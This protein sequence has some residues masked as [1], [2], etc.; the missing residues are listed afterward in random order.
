[1]TPL[2]KV[3]NIPT[4]TTMSESFS[5]NVESKQNPPLQP[6]EKSV[7]AEFHQED[8]STISVG[9]KHSSKKNIRPTKS[10]KTLEVVL[11]SRGKDL[12]QFWN[13][14]AEERS[15]NLWLPTK[16]GCVVSDL[17]CSNSLSHDSPMEK[18]LCSVTV[19]VPKTKNLCPIS[20]PSSLSSLLESTDFGST[21][22]VF[23][24][25]L[26]QTIKPKK[27]PKKKQKPIPEGYHLRTMKF[28][29]H[30]T[31]KQKNVLNRL[32]GIYRW[33]FNEAKYYGE[34]YKIYS[35]QKLRNK[36]RER[37]GNHK[38]AVPPKWNFSTIPERI[39]T[40]AVKDY[41]SAMEGC[42]TKMKDKQITHFDI[43]IK[44]KKHPTQTLLIPHECFSFSKGNV[45][46]SGLKFSDSDTTKG[47]HLNGVYKCGKKGQKKK[48]FLKD[49]RIEH[50]CRI[51]YVNSNFYLLVP[52]YK[53]EAVSKPSNLIVSIDSGIRTFQACYCPEGHT[54]DICKNVGKHIENLY[55][56]LDDLNQ[57]YFNTR[58]N[59]SFTR[60]LKGKRT[61]IHLRRK[62]IFEKIRNMVDDLHWKT[63][64][65]L[66]DGYRD[67][68]ISDFKTKK[69]LEL[70]DLN[71]IS[72]R[73][74]CS[75]RHYVF[76][77]RLIE[78]CKS[79][80][81]YLFI[82]DEAYTTKTCG[83]CGILNQSLGSKKTFFCEKCNL[84]ID[85]DTNASRNMLLRLLYYVD[86]CT[87]KVTL[88]SCATA[89]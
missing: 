82:V 22:Q 44:T 16:T 34:K 19:H 61:R 56:K 72:K 25:T 37:T 80:K 43:H 52:Y 54:A 78:A 83:R 12:K 88:F 53:Y 70:P 31:L 63:I 27:K 13:T 62:R 85:R 76:R 60:D 45:L 39:I 11:T 30:P 84:E 58:K 24:P 89:G 77:Q 51:S 29:L 28:R 4:D 74:L 5:P 59:G 18:S 26:E 64:K 40:G 33:G 6:V 2:E 65:F 32:F 57:K 55:D 38:Y 14:P 75:L 50:D 71:R 46:F 42:F 67:I 68:I 69:L 49:I 17:K 1:L 8:K 23:N 81:N 47:L 41:A 79:R 20:Y 66:T 9:K 15:K 10:L 48:I 3:G 86:L 7:T 73:R 21:V 35:F 87:G 36:M